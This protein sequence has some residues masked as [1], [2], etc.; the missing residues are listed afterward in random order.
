[1]Q[2]SDGR[3]VAH[4]MTA[5]VTRPGNRRF[6]IT[7][8]EG[9]VGPGQGSID[10]QGDVRLT[11]ADG[12]VA[13]TPTASYSKGE[14]ILRA[15]GPVTFERGKT[16]R[17]ASP[18]TKRDTMW[19]LDQARD[20]S[21]KQRHRRHGCLAPSAESATT[22]MRL[23]RQARD[24]PGQTFA[25]GDMMVTCCCPIA[26]RWKLQQRT[27]PATG[28]S[29]RAMEARDIFSITPT[30]AARCNVT[31]SGNAS[32]TLAGAAGQPGQRLAAEFVDRP[33]RTAPCN[34]SPANA[35]RCAAVGGTVPARTIRT[36]G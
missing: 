1:V 16:R 6:V 36:D 25:A 28:G 14:G 9:T 30:V 8:K 13:K 4:D 35:C 15:P 2:Y 3:S 27:S 10:M 21:P 11:S 12:L 17:R 19:V 22:A 29:L 5:T 33:Q 34:Q 18:P 26:T 31:L 24:A 23:E 20:A 7:A 32:I